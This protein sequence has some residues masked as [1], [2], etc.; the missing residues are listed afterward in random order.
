VCPTCNDALVAHGEDTFRCQENHH[1]TVVGLALTT[2]I[3]A[4]RALWLA[5]RALE[6]DAASLNYMATHYG[7]D[8]GMSADA[9]RAEATAAIAAAETLRKHAQRAQERLDALPA[10]PSIASEIGSQTGQDG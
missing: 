2:N 7:D 1:Y 8:Y 3:A 10:A 4:L 6:D 9:R 5:I